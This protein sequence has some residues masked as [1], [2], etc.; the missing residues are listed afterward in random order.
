MDMEYPELIAYV[1]GQLQSGAPVDVI[2]SSLLNSGWEDKDIDE[3]FSKVR[4]QAD[5]IN[6]AALGGA[7]Q[8]ALSRDEQFQAAAQQSPSVYPE[9]Q[10]NL[11]ATV[12][13]PDI[14][15][16]MIEG[17]ETS[18]AH[19]PPYRSVLKWLG[20]VV[21]LML[22]GAGG[23]FAYQRGWI[24]FISGAPYNS[25]EVL[26]EGFSKLADI[27]SA[28]YTVTGLFE[29]Q[30]R[31]ADATPYVYDESK[32][33][34]LRPAYRRDKMRIE[35]IK[36][37]K[38][39]V[40]LGGIY[41]QTLGA[42]ESV[43]SEI[44]SSFVYT[45][46]RKGAGYELA[47]TFETD[48]AV[49][50][51]EEAATQ[52]SYS[53]GFGG[54]SGGTVRVVGK[55]IIFTEAMQ[56]PYFVDFSGEPPKPL[57]VQSLETV[58]KMLATISDNTR[59]NISMSGATQSQK[60]DE[61]NTESKTNAEISISADLELGDSSMMFGF[62]GKIVDENVYLRLNKFPG[63]IPFFN[64]SAI[65]G[66]WVKVDKSDT[67]SYL[68]VS[69]GEQQKLQEKS[70][71]QGKDALNIALE[72]K[73]FIVTGGPE[74]SDI[75][76]V[77]AYRYGFAV[78]RDAAAKVAKRFRDE[79]LKKADNDGLQND[80]DKKY[81]EFVAFLESDD[82]REMFDYMGK[83]M[84]FNVWFSKEGFPIKYE[85]NT[86][87]VPL[88]DNPNLDKLQFAT[89]F[90][91]LLENI[92]KPIVIEAPKEFI[93][94]DEAAGLVSG[95]ALFTAREKAV[96]AAIKSNLS[97]MRP[98]AELFY[99]KKGSYGP[100]LSEGSCTAESRIKE[101]IFGSDD[102][103]SRSL[104]AVQTSGAKIIYCAASPTSYAIA[105]SLTSDGGG[106]YCVDSKNGARDVS[107]SPKEDIILGK[108]L[109]N[110]PYKCGF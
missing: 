52:P 40:A 101:S 8:G 14:Q 82:F 12:S 6:Q 44:A 53:F 39:N 72:E 92:N 89:T 77:R 20:I 93:T 38:G 1:K 43:P 74:R 87:F 27:S 71:K 80:Y 108:G 102:M 56:I 17:T 96:D 107:G 95:G 33:E 3:A 42:A 26:A 37:F 83:N 9:A 29:V 100:S 30:P 60:S 70:I 25:D 23:V 63:I 49:K 84:S 88:G 105:A 78:N 32:L 15:H 19:R 34:A 4:T 22:V 65:K 98:T 81:E 76:D 75:G 24:P 18:S 54:G 35:V 7:V 99:D 47:V 103:M 67:S 48:D 62:D 16:P 97:N 73:L 13:T 68:N 10:P 91:A 55:K 2:R 109:S 61:K 51:M 64:S 58:G 57:W 45:Q 85:Y 21:V 94:A 106:Y 31:A 79:V 11:V 66:K 110:D 90:T 28:S 69:V 41:P 59:V 104:K 36:S 86:R 50:A 46:T 5:R